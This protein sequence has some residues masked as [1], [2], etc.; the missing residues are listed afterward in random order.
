ME[1][2]MP[3]MFLAMYSYWWKAALG[4]RD[5]STSVIVLVPE[6]TAPELAITT[7]GSVTEYQG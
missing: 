7:S 1:I 4:P 5:Q 2:V 3:L 6:D